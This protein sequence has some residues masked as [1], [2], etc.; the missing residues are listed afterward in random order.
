MVFFLRFWRIGCLAVV[1]SFAVSV[2]AETPKK[3]NSPKPKKEQVAAVDRA[4]PAEAGTTNE[5]LTP[6]SL[7]R[8]L[9]AGLDGANKF[10]TI[11]D[12]QFLRRTSL[13]LIGRQPTPDEMAVFLNETS[14]DKRRGEIERLLNSKEFGSNWA[15][16]WSDTISY[17]VSPP[18]LTFLNYDAL[19]SW[20]ADRLNDNTPWDEVVR[21]IL[22]ASGK[23]K[24]RPPATF[25][26]YHQADPVKLAAE[27]ARVFL[28][29]QIQCA[30]CHNHP[31]EDWKRE[32]FHHLAA[33]FAR[34]SVKMPWNDGLETEIKDAGKGEY[35]MPNVKDPKQK[36]TPMI[37]AF[38]TGAT[39]EEGKSDVERRTSLAALVAGRDNKWFAKAYANRIWGRLMGR[40]FCEPVDNISAEQKRLLPEVHD[41]LTAE[42]NQSAFDVKGL[43]RLIANTQA[44]QQRL[45]HDEVAATKPFASARP[46]KLRGDE[47][48]TSL[49]TA[50]DLPNVTPPKVKPTPEIRFPPPP[51][52]TRDLVA[53]T[54]GFDPSLTPEEISRTINQA[55]LLMNN[56]QLQAQIN[57]KP[58]SGTMLGKLLAAEKDDAAAFHRLFQIVL[59]RKPSE[60]EVGLAMDHV[61]SVGDRGPAFEDLLWSLINST[62]FTTRR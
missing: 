42:F 29:V 32:Q 50:I 18:E 1:L 38:L 56:D 8:M 53:E 26:A 6:E 43:L 62:E 31:F 17:R 22:T 3:A 14:S 15:N 4:T 57:A 25:V 5:R 58:D 54:F 36:G 2:R 19:K 60:K 11:S 41:A 21:E 45:A 40:G 35:L 10:E 44:Y 34:A 39:L 48:F 51:K 49:V 23:V 9:A 59:A 30:Q 12:E 33:Y 52:S 46:A 16:Y 13:D 20:L 37:P 27:T 24:D 55:M 7:D 28:G 61:K 47:V